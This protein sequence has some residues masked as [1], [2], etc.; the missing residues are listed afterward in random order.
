[1]FFP[2]WTAADPVSLTSRTSGQEEGER[3]FAVFTLKVS[4]YVCVYVYTH[5]CRRACGWA[6]GQ[7]LLSGFIP[8]YTVHLDF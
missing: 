5:A 1:M 6:I 3:S 7:R 2:F 4:V 8:Q